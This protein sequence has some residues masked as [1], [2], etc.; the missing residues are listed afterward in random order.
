MKRLLRRLG[1]PAVVAACI[2]IGWLTGAWLGHAL[3]GVLAGLC[4]LLAARL[5]QQALSADRLLRWLR[6]GATAAEPDDGGRWSEIAR[7]AARAL[8]ERERARVQERDRLT[9]FLA[10]V[11]ASPVG[12]L[13]LDADQRISWISHAAAAHLGLQPRRDLLQHV[14]HL[15]RAPAFVEQLA[16]ADGGAQPAL[17]SNRD[18][19][20][21]ATLVRPYGEGL[22]LVLTQDVT[23][24]ERVEA[25][26]R[27]FVADVSHEIRTPLTVLAG[28]VETL[29]DLPLSDAERARVLDLMTAQAVRM[30][31]LVDDLLTL[32]RLEGNPRPPAD[33][34]L[35]AR[36]LMERAHADGLELSAGQHRLRLSGGEGV[37]VA[38]DEAELLSALSNLV[39]NAV[40]YTPGGGDIEIG[41][42]HSRSGGGIFAVRDTGIG[43]AREHLPR[44]TERFYRVDGSRSRETGGTGL[45]LAIV[46]HVAQRHDGEIEIRSEP[47]RG[48]L[49]RL[50]LPAARVRGLGAAREGDAG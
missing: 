11:D 43:I 19:N 5:A 46:K 24:R 25:M 22:R 21:L 32:A 29:R 35:A 39:V 40:R 4:L 38:G 16:A 6:S 15:V 9:Q 13:L 8:A 27:S 14:T 45:G 49:F 7:Q 50:L 42:S 37:E 17:F 28:F 44:L 1:T 33:R 36:T 12:V 3:T 20:R 31:R 48:S 26:R 18:G 47:G 23:E 41:W 10:A 30:Q 34:W 2:A